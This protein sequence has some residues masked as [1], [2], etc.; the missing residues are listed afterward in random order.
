MKKKE[1]VTVSEFAEIFDVSPE[2]VRRWV[3]LG[4]IKGFKTNPFQ[5]KTAPVFIPVSEL[6]R[7]KSLVEE[8]QNEPN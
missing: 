6:E 3:R 1:T 7:V 4:K 8:N 5:A 2:T